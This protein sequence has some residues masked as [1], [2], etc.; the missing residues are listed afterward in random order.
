M[1]EKRER[2]EETE[3]HQTR[4]D[5]SEKQPRLEDEDDKPT[6]VEEESVAASG[7]QCNTGGDGD[8]IGYQENVT[9]K[10]ECKIY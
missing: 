5:S 7:K 3:V 9:D 10:Y 8:R 4:T 6:K 1:A 2:S